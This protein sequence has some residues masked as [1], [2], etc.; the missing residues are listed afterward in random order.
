MKLAMRKVVICQSDNCAGACYLNSNK[1]SMAITLITS[2]HVRVD[3]KDWLIGQQGN[4]L[5]RGAASV[6]RNI[7]DLCGSVVVPMREPFAI[8]L[9]FDYD[10]TLLVDDTNTTF[11]NG[12]RN[13]DTIFLGAGALCMV[14]LLYVFPF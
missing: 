2:P 1:L 10:K 13:L 14:A 3:Q 11:W 8:A 4:D 7:S 12:A 6:K 5:G 9:K